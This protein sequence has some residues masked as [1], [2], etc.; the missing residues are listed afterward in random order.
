MS[1]PCDVRPFGELDL[2]LAARF[3]RDA[4]A[5]RGERAWTRQDMAE[6]LASPGVFGLFLQ[7]DGKEIGFALS[8]VVAD[9]AELL[10]IAI[11]AGHRRCGAGR[12][13]LRQVIEATGARGAA[14]LFLE[15]AADNPAARALYAQTGFQE[16]GRRR[17]Y[18]TRG[19]CP[20][21][22]AVVLRL[23]FK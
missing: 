21:A 12:A 13:L 17:G 18:Y 8:R 3:H 5:V 20:A 7:R 11:D 15:V 22:D 2:D 1:A 4:I 14:T 19:A 16:V 9:E 10:T 23:A 6:L